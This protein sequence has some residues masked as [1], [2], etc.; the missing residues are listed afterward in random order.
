MTLKSPS[1]D[2]SLPD[3]EKAVALKTMSILRFAHMSIWIIDAQVDSA[4]LQ[5]EF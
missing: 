3:G 4:E 1:P 2:L 5:I